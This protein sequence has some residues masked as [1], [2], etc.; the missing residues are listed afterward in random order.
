LAKLVL[1][2]MP[3][4]MLSGELAVAS[5]R[6]VLIPGSTEQPVSRIRNHGSKLRCKRR[7]CYDIVST[8]FEIHTWLCM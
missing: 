2:E 4:I 8:S 5:S 7:D 1:G 3:V 6:M